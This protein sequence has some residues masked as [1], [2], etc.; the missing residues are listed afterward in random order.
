MLEGQ[1]RKGR[2][3]NRLVFILSVIAGTMGVV[4]SVFADSPRQARPYLSLGYTG[5]SDAEFKDPWAGSEV[6]LSEYRVVA[7]TPQWSPGTWHLSTGLDYQYTRF[8]YRGIE[9]RNR[10]LHRLQ[11]PLF[12][13]RP[14]GQWVVD[15]FLAPGV[16]TSS[17]VMKDLWDEASGDDFILTAR[18]EARKPQSSEFGWIL[19]LA[20]D[21]SLGDDQLLPVA[22][23]D[24]QPRDDLS[25]RLAFPDSELIWSRSSRHVA[26]LRF[27]PAGHRWH[28]ESDELMDDFD[29]ELEAWRLQGVWSFRFWR[30]VWLDFS[31]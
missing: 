10:D 30:A 1:N 21:R 17:N 16:S 5:A 29:Y 31:V 3:V 2:E 14:L 19:G 23:V 6:D 9:G 22:G 8:E 12:F 11:V 7:G 24:W 27:F 13:E 18:A 28:V 26:S 15:G 4:L 25:L 20:W